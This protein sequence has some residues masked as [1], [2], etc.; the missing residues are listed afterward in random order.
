MNMVH[1]RADRHS[2]KRSFNGWSS[3]G[4][5]VGCGRAVCPTLHSLDDNGHAIRNV[6]N[7][8]DTLKTKMENNETPLK[9]C[10]YSEIFHNL[11]E[12]CGKIMFLYWCI[13]SRPST[14]IQ[15][16][17]S[18]ALVFRV[19]RD[20]N[21]FAMDKNPDIFRGDKHPDKFGTSGH[22]RAKNVFINRKF[23]FVGNMS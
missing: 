9:T 20:L 6:G 18:A 12:K 7:Q 2:G 16:P 22:Y 10:Y 19:N 23:I 21:T 17:H 1:W 5:N 3:H 15:R 14:R 8:N 13:I 11:T 4:V